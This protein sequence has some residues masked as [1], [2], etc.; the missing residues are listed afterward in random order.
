MDDEPILGHYGTGYEQDRLNQGTSRIEFARTK[1]LLQRFLP[2]PPADVL[3]VGGGP[4]TYASW[5]AGLGYRVHL[6]DV[7]PLHVEQAARAR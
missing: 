3:D 2:P 6:V 7:V 5:L 1:E 4:G